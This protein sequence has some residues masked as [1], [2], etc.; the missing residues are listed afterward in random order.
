MFNK[1]IYKELK[2]GIIE[3]C[4]QFNDIISI[5]FEFEVNNA[6][7]LIQ[8]N[9]KLYTLSSIKTPI[10]SNI[11]LR[12]DTPRFEKSFKYNYSINNNYDRNF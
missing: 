2:G 9:N 1:V 5:G 6:I 7:M 10:Y 3:N 4:K 11:L 8:Q 12:T